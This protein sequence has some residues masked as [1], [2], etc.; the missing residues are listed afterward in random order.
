VPAAPLADA[1][2]SGRPSILAPLEEALLQWFFELREQGFMVSVRLIKLRAC[3]LS[4]F[5]EKR[6]GKTIWQFVDSLQAIKLFCE[7]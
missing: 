5:V 1:E 3:E 4:A 2:G 6:Y 7:Q